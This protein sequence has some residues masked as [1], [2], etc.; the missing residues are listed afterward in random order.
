MKRQM[1]N[2]LLIQCL[3]ADQIGDFLFEHNTCFLGWDKKHEQSN[4]KCN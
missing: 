3:K 1:Y 4:F 2:K